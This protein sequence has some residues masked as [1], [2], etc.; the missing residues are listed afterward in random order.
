TENAFFRKIGLRKSMHKFDGL[1]I[2][3]SAGT[4]NAAE[5]V[6]AQPELNG[7]AVDPEYRRF[8]KGLGLT[9]VN[10]LPH[11]QMTKSFMLDGMR[12]FEDITYGDSFG[13]RFLVLPDG[14]YY[15]CIEGQ[16][17]VWGEAY[18][19]ADGQIRLICADREHRSYS[20]DIVAM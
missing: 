2:G 13:R 19:I 11:Y 14:S 17:T 1:V 9:N 5:V 7:E 3:I 10:I 20:S 18:E 16:G 4:M 6:Y 8:I 12:L 15:T